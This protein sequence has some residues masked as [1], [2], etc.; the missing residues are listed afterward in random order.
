MR[1][2]VV[3][4]AVPMAGAWHA[5]ALAEGSVEKVPGEDRLRGLRQPRQPGGGAAGIR[6]AGMSMRAMAAAAPPY[7]NATR[8]KRP[9]PDI[10]QRSPEAC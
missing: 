7:P 8:L 5:S 4:L 2:R 6:A 9:K 10:P 3:A 1:A